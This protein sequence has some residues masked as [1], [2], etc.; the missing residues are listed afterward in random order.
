M[1]T[2]KKYTRDLFL[3]LSPEKR[4]N[5]MDAAIS[6][7]SHTGINGCN[8]RDIAARIG[9]SHGSLFHY[10]S[11]KDDMIHV[12]IQD[13]YAEQV[14]LFT[15]NIEDHDDVMEVLHSIIRYS[16]EYSVSHRMIV[17][18]WLELSLPCNS[19]FSMHTFDMEKSAIEFLKIIVEKGK[20]AGAI[21]DDLDTDTTAYM[22]DSILANILKS[23]VSEIER[24]KFQTHFGGDAGD[25]GIITGKLMALLRAVLQSAE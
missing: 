1:I 22:I 18:I 2:K 17:S 4:K 14:D 7:F 9:I 12:I 6:E 19:R 10:F 3:K 21:R 16:L 11:S 15:R 5:I 25:T 8:V 24:K 13:G 23:H 20:K